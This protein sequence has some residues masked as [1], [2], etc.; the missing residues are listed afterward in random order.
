MIRLSALIL[1]ILW[2]SYSYAAIGFNLTDL[3]EDTAPTMDDLTFV[4]NDPATTHGP[5]KATLSNVFLSYA[6]TYV[7]SLTEDTGPSGSDL[8]MTV[9]DPSGSALPKK[10]T[11]DNFASSVSNSSGW[12]D[13]GSTVYSVTN[14]DNVGIGVSLATQKLHVNGNVRISGLISCD[15]IDTDAAGNLS[16]GTDTGGGGTT[17]DATLY[18]TTTFGAG[19]IFAWTFNAGATDPVLSFTSGAVDLNSAS[20]TIHGT[21]SQVKFANNMFIN[22]DTSRNIKIGSTGGSN[23]E[24]LLIDND[25]TANAFGIS[26]DTGVTKV[27]FGTIALANT[28][29]INSFGNVSIGTAGAPASGLVVASNVSI[30]TAYAVAHA[31][32]T[33]GLVVQGNVGIGTWLATQALDVN[34]SVKATSFITT[35][36][37]AGEA[38]FYQP[39]GSGSNYVAL[40]APT[41][42]ASSV[43]WTLPNADGTNGQLIQTN[44][45]G[46]LSW[47]SVAAGTLSGLTTNYITKAT[48]SSSAGDSVMFDN[49]TNVGVGTITPVSKFSVAGN[50]AIG[51]YA[52]VNSASANSLIVSG[53]LGVGTFNQANS[54]DVNGAVAVGS[55]AGIN[56]AQSNGLIVSGNVG[57][58]THTPGASL[59]VGSTGQFKVS[60]AGSIT[61]LT[62]DTSAVLSSTTLSLNN[63]TA[64]ATVQ[65]VGSGSNS[66]LAIKT[67]TGSGSKMTFFTA[68]SQRA[69]LDGSGN[70]GVGTSVLNNKLE[71]KGNAAFGSYAGI[72]SSASNGIIVSGNLGIGTFNPL[73]T[74]QV[75]TGTDQNGGFQ[76]PQ[77]LADGVAFVSTNDAN[78][79]NKSLELRGSTVQ[80][81]SIGAF[82]INF[83]TNDS[84]NSQSTIRMVI[85]SAGNVGMG[86]LTPGT[87]L[88]VQG[89]IRATGYKSS[90]G[91][92]GATV[93][94]C[95]GFKNGLCISGS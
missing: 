81:S 89:N 44:G 64:T 77:N 32:P 9:H 38:D 79:A 68:N 88:D 67:G 60:S 14:T 43:T 34:G 47:T 54:L 22:G 90:D 66:D 78:S 37:T 95:T 17:F 3:T 59:A 23:N 56:A 27:N 20:F 6:H 73:N 50:M 18:G 48:S 30:G 19:S 10:V 74:F 57:I 12:R 87:K 41:S 7:P 61:S 28:S 45:S 65:Q 1:L 62:G 36:T 35:N 31:A 42:I 16:C 49:G 39:S 91:T 58:G 84:G 92:A 40:K 63:S 5:R 24:D 15:T 82:P 85:D 11:I 46:T 26:S 51:A 93:T 8:I 55:Y 4:V 83:L 72:Y 33:N 53:N 70:L 21:N 25:T 76:G 86:S 2:P 94:T 29:T 80:L 69:V 75:R 13:G 71:V 52:G